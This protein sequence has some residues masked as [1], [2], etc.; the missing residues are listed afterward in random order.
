[1]R[2]EH[3]EGEVE[4]AEDGGSAASTIIGELATSFF[5]DPEAEAGMMYGK[6]ELIEEGGI[7]EFR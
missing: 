1:M 5:T 3:K 7:V 6:W 4:G 2:G